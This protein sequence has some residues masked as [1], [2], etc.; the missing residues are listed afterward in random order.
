MNPTNSLEQ[1]ISS[2]F[3][4]YKNKAVD[5]QQ[6]EIISRGFVYSKV[7][8][9]ADILI[10]GINPSER[11]D[12][13]TSDYMYNY[14]LLEKDRYFKKFLPLFSNYTNTFS[15]SYFDLFYQKHSKQKSIECFKKDKPGKDFLQEQLNITHSILEQIQPKA[16]FVFNKQAST[17]FNHN[18]NFNVGLNLK[19]EKT[20]F[21]NTY[22]VQSNSLKNTLV[23]SSR[24][25]N[26][27]VKME[28]LNKI[29]QEIASVFNLIRS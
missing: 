16:I 21:P 25:L 19:L 18:H 17:F 1:K 5:E 12:F 22:H 11:K 7:D 13:L 24:F 27:F 2:L 26:H 23:Y 10:C 4:R 28:E 29:K 9:K 14:A 6:K 15:I 20:A 8:S 3:S